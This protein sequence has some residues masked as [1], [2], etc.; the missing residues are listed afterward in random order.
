MAAHVQL[1]PEDDAVTTQRVHE[2]RLDYDDIIAA[3]DGPRLH[4]NDEV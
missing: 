4:I 2:I 3:L 1:V